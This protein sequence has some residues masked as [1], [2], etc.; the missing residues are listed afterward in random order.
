MENPTF[1][2]EF[3]WGVSTSAFQIEGATGEGGRGQSIWDTF[4]ATEG[5]IARAEHAKIAADHFHRYS[6][7]IALLAELGVGAYRMSFAWP[8]IQPDGEG[9]PNAE[10]LAF[11]DELLDEVC[12]AGIAPTGTLFHWD[13]PQALEDKG[14]WLSRDTAERFGEYADILGERFSDRVKMWI[15]LNEPMV[16]SIYGYAIGE[17]APGKTL[18]LDALPTAHY[19]NLAHGLAVQALRAAGARSVGTANNHSPIWPASDS[20]EDKAAGEWIDALINRTYADPVLLGRYPEQVVEHLPRDFADDL[21]TIAQPLDFYGVNYYEPQG[22]AAPGEG[23]P[24]PFEL[25]AIEGYPMTTNDSPIVPHGLRELL[26]GFHERYREH[27]PPVYITENGCSFDD[28]VAEDGHVHDQ[29]RIDFLDSH[30]VAVRE[31]MDAGVDVRGYFVW[32]L[33]DNFEWSKGYQ[34]RFGLV[35]IDYETQKRTPKDSFGWYRELIRH[36]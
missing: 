31:A 20:P 24:L 32:S 6:E 28:V 33:M 4:T 1:P 3:L 19:Q 21:P 14:G 22:V 23:N 25:R 12:A 11:Y 13:L 17:Y 27:L 5:K 35:H 9:K 10:G 29:E 18:L 36:E 16:M 34:P 26:V 8:R 15:P 7:D 30:L 2:S